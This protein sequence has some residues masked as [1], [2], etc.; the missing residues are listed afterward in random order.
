MKIVA[1]IR[2]AAAKKAEERRT[3]LVRTLNKQFDRYVELYNS[4]GPA[5]ADAFASKVGIMHLRHRVRR[6][7]KPASQAKHAA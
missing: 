3:E 2:L 7:L 4:K 6:E 1:E 5:E